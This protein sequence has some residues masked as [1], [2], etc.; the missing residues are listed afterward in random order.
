MREG[1]SGDTQT[2]EHQVGTG[3]S[4]SEVVS[5]CWDRTWPAIAPLWPP[6]RSLLAM[7]QI[8]GTTSTHGKT[9]TMRS[10]LW[11]LVVRLSGQASRAQHTVQPEDI[12]GLPC[13]YL[14]HLDRMAGG[15]ATLYFSG[16]ERSY[17]PPTG[18]AAARMLVR[19]FSVACKP[20]HQGLGSF[21]TRG[22]VAR[23][24]LMAVLQRLCAMS[25]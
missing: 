14:P 4:L 3:E 17:R 20:A 16:F 11:N 18:L 21:L 2:E 13:G 7:F 23:C 24:D 5:Q 25:Q 10:T 1:H 9:C 15:S 8:C 22:R 19:A 6:C 12:N